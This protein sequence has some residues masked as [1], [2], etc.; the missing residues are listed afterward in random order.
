MPNDINNLDTQDEGLKAIFGDRFHDETTEKPNVA[1]KTRKAKNPAKAVKAPAI[2]TKTE[3]ATRKEGK[4]KPDPNWL[5][6]LKDAVKWVS[7]FAGLCLL[8]FYWQQTGQME[9]S[10]ALPSMLVCMALAG[11]SAGR[12]MKGSC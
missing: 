5:D 7:L 6:R 8:F 9:A 1:K 2:E 3:P 11:V 4:W 10:A 12:N